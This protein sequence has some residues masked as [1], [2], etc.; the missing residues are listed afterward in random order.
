M[1]FEAEPASITGITPL[2][3]YCCDSLSYCGSSS[4]AP[5][6]SALLPLLPPSISL[7]PFTDIPKL[8]YPSASTS[9]SPNL[10]LSRPVT[11]QMPALGVLAHGHCPDYPKSHGLFFSLNFLLSCHRI[12]FCVSSALPGHSLRQV[13]DLSEFGLCSSVLTYLLFPLCLPL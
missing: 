9:A 13:F 3:L 2:R 1:T 8:V 7:S 5:V 12:F 6:P 10:S 4:F 11:S